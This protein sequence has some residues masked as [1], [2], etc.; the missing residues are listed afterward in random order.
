MHGLKATVVVVVHGVGC[1]EWG[2]E[3]VVGRV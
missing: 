1:G 2:G 3:L